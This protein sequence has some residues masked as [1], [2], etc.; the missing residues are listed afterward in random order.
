MKFGVDTSVF[1]NLFTAETPVKDINFEYSIPGL[2]KFTL[3]ALDVSF[4]VDG[5]AY[6]RPIIRGF[7]VLLMLLFH[8]K[9]CIGFFGY[10][11]GVVTGRSEHIAEAKKAQKEG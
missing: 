4:F 8:V 3:P 5:V 9:Q 11:A 7:L 2:G 6:F 10:D 1:E